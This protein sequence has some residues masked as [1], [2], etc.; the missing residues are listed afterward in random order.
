[1]V[2]TDFD[3]IEALSRTGKRDP[4][5]LADL[6]RRYAVLADKVGKFHHTQADLI[7]ISNEFRSVLSQTAAALLSL[8]QAKSANDQ[9]GISSGV[10]ELERL[11]R[12]EQLAALQFGTQ[13]RS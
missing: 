2:N 7:P 11:S 6:A 12:R 10:L 9:S 4:R 1:M 13:C 8:S 3:A 5:T